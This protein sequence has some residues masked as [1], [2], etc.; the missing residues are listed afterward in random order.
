MGKMLAN[1]LCI[2]MLEALEAHTVKENQYGYNFGIRKT[3]GLVA[4]DFAIADL[5][6]FEFG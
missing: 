4:M 2:K 5:M 1:I 6:F 3:S